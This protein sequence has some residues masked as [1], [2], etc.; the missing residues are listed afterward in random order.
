MSTVPPRH[1]KYRSKLCRNFIS[2]DCTFG[3]KCSFLHP[4]LR[5]VPASGPFSRRLLLNWNALFPQLIPLSGQQ[6][7]PATQLPPS[8]QPQAFLDEDPSSS[9]SLLLS[10]SDC[11]HSE[12]IPEARKHNN[13]RKKYPCRHFA[14]TG[15][16]CPAGERC[17]FNHDWSAMQPFTAEEPEEASHLDS[18]AYD[19]EGRTI[20]G[21]VLVGVLPPSQHTVQEYPE[22][23][24]SSQYS[25]AEEV[26]RYP[27]YP[28]SPW[29]WPSHFWPPHPA[30][31][32]SYPAPVT[33]TVPIPSA[34]S[35]PPP[36]TVTQHSDYPLQAPIEV[37]G[38]LPTGAFEINGTTYFSPPTAHAPPP[39]PPAFMAPV[40]Q[41]SYS[42][43]IPPPC[44]YYPPPPPTNYH[45]TGGPSVDSWRQASFD[46]FGSEA[47]ITEGLPVVPRLQ[48]YHLAPVRPCTLPPPRTAEL[49]VNQPDTEADTQTSTQEHEFPYRPPNNQRVGHARR[50]S[51][52]IKK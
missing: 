50:I 45:T 43:M 11:T 34:V 52:N 17:K 1:P 36:S 23:P 2:G 33:I 46:P 21:G 38:G 35:L 42:Q 12:P 31:Y 29:Y 32:A 7:A 24:P 3:A 20:S 27:D 37:S 39:P 18:E 15:G 19:A 30:Y 44:P 22:G 40:H 49:G 16:W 10:A 28:A 6:G 41:V 51:V 5:M 26:K 14:R 9:N 8:S 48:G 47:V 4:P 25:L 13:R